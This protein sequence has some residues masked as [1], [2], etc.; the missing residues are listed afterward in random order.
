MQRL[1]ER[2]CLITGG[3]GSIGFAT[4]RRFRDEGATVILADRDAEKLERRAAG[5]EAFIPLVA[6]VSREDDVR[7]VLRGVAER[8]GRLDALVNNAAGWVNDG[9]I[10]DISEE[11]WDRVQAATLKSVFLCSKYAL[12]LMRKQKSGAIVNVASVNAVFG[13]AL[14]AYSAAKGGILSLTR[15]M[16][17][18]HGPEGIR[19]NAISPGTIQT[20]SWEPLLAKNPRA[21]D[22]WEERYPLR[23]VG[24]P[25]EVAALAAY[26]A[27][28]DAAN[29]TGANLVMDGGLSAGLVV[30]G[31]GPA[32]RDDEET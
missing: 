11:D 9:P 5:E 8:F 16:A 30:P 13:L 29:T 3:A 23:R 14:A 19:V 20:D 2:V 27:S 28:D 7:A 12:T 1:K 32:L 22:E 26:L 31:Y 17:V 10:T 15:V 21:L 24:T 18:M 4:A 6:D 25:E